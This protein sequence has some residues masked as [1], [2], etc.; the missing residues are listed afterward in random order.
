MAGKPIKN[1]Q[2]A[3]KFSYSEMYDKFR[4]QEGLKA[5]E[6][7]ESPEINLGQTI[8][9]RHTPDKIALHWFGKAGSAQKYTFGDLSR[10]TNRFANLLRSMGVRKGDRVAG[11]LPRIPE[12]LIVMIG[13]WKAGAS[14]VPIFTGLGPDAIRFRVQQSQARIICTQWE[15]RM[16]VPQKLPG[17]QAV[18][19]VAGPQ[20]DGLESGDVGI[21]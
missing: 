17:V 15:H 13:T 6:W 19:S 14:Y 3:R 18:I 9:D 1:H 7:G 16:R 11:F 2:M 21:Y 10:L 4:W 5:L 20:G 12:T 8:L